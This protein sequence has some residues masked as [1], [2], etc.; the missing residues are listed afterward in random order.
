MEGSGDSS[1]STGQDT[2]SGHSSYYEGDSSSAPT[3]WST[4]QSYQNE[5]EAQ[6]SLP[7]L[8]L[9]D[10][11][12]NS[13]QSNDFR[14]DQG[15]KPTEQDLDLDQGQPDRTREHAPELI[16]PSDSTDDCFLTYTMFQQRYC[17]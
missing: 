17:S 15:G 9:G 4:N 2:R 6:F 16:E 3:S 5:N 13:I 10:E 1:S 11:Y 12:A 8:D 7:P 14:P